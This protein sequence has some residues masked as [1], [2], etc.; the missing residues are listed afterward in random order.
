M[1]LRV[2]ESQAILCRHGR[3]LTARGA[4]QQSAHCVSSS[5]S[6]R[7][8]SGG[9]S[10]GASGG[11]SSESPARPWWSGEMA[12]MAAARQSSADHDESAGTDLGLQYC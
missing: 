9:S 4:S 1:S 5:S 3:N 7:G 12:R 6:S 2:H 10:R 11:S 8:A